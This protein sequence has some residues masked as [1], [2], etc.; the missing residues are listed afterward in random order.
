MKTSA[1]AIDPFSLLLSFK[2]LCD[3][4]PTGN[5]TQAVMVA[6]MS[7]FLTVM[8]SKVMPAASNSTDLSKATFDVLAA[9]GGAAYTGSYMD[10]SKSFSM[11]DMLQVVTSFGTVLSVAKSVGLKFS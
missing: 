6:S 1:L 8:T 9:L 5:S 11:S 7:K 10:L 2:K 4:V 3:V